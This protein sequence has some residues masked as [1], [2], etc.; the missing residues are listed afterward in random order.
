VVVV[1]TAAICSFA[2]VSR[3]L[4]KLDLVGVLKARD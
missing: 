3:M 4:A 1:L 2:L